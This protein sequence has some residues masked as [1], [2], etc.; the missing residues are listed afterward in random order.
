MDSKSVRLGVLCSS[1]VSTIF[2]RSATMD[3][4]N[5]ASEEHLFFQLTMVHGGV[6]LASEHSRFPASVAP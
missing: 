5:I 1:C 3:A 2:Q 4:L 6:S